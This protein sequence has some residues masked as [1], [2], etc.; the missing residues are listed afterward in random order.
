MKAPATLHTWRTSRP[1]RPRGSLGRF[2]Q[3]IDEAIAEAM[4]LLGYDGQWIVLC[5]KNHICFVKFVGEWMHRAHLHAQGGGIHY[6][7]PDPVR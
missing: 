6:A 5:E 4:N 3:E 7:E 2:A 1:G